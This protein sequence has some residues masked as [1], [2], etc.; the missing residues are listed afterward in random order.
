MFRFF[1]A[2]ETGKPGVI[3]GPVGIAMLIGVLLIVQFAWPGKEKLVPDQDRVDRVRKSHGN[4]SHYAKPL[5]SGTGVTT[6]AVPDL[7]TALGERKRQDAERNQV[8]SDKGVAPPSEWGRTTPARTGIS[9]SRTPSVSGKAY[10]Q[11]SMPG[12]DTSTMEKATI[13]PHY[14]PTPDPKMRI[15]D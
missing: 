8:L 9:I 11:R 10:V 1:K 2:R 7:R 14:T 5:M 12:V 13:P 6:P 15:L 4:E 3:T